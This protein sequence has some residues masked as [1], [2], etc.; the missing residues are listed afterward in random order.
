M[1]FSDFDFSG[2]SIF[3]FLVCL[4]YGAGT[5]NEKRHYRS[6]RIREQQFSHVAAVTTEEAVDV[7]YDQRAELVVGSVVISIDYF[8]RIVAAIRNILG[9]RVTSYESLVERARREALLRMKEK[10]ARRGYGRVINVRLETAAIGAR[11]N[12]KHTVGSVETIAYG[13]AI[14]EPQT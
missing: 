10:A 8:K 14:G 12:K 5:F 4:G 13:T 6:L 7:R 1:N 9:G 3:I 2:I 11:A